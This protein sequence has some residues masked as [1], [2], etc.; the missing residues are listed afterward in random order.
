M[1]NNNLSFKKS[2]SNMQAVC[3]D[4]RK[5]TK[6]KKIYY[7]IC[8]WTGLM[9]FWC[10]WNQRSLFWDLL[11]LFSSQSHLNS[12]PPSK[13]L[14]GDLGLLTCGSIRR[15][16]PNDTFLCSSYSQVLLSVFRK[17]VSVQ[18]RLEELIDLFSE[19]MRQQA[20]GARNYL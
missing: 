5:A 10:N 11:F 4:K 16:Q 15:S 12:F 8:P 6:L 19:S 2:T 20:R 1:F 7:K 17:Q 18:D 13:T 9:S 3:T 14:F